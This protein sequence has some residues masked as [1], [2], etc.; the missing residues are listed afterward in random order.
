M[1]AVC[2]L[3]CWF[4]F[5]CAV[6]TFSN[7]TEAALTVAALAY[8]PW[9]GAAS[10][11]DDVK[12]VN[13]PLSLALAAA[14]C[15]VRP[16]AALYWLPMFV[17][18]SVKS[19]SRVR[20]ILN[21]ALPIGAAALAISTCVDRVF[22]GR[23]EIVPWN[24][25]GSTPWTAAAPSTAR[26]LG[27]GTSPRDTPAIATVFLPLA[28]IA[29]RDKK[30]WAPSPSSDG[31]FLGTLSPRTRSFGFC[32]RRWPDARRR[33]CAARVLLLSQTRRRGGANPSHADPRGA[34][35]VPPAPE[36]H[37]LGDVRADAAVGRRRAHSAGILADALPPAPV[38]HPRAQ[39]ERRHALSEVRSSRVRNPQGRAGRG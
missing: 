38:D 6:R 37:R 13:R 11:N 3:A 32:S 12:N 33:R 22:Y 9:T 26:T 7:C 23:W 29:C 8:W 30:R 1:G 4:N 2:S 10:E 15:V 5:F 28:A 34:V 24:F 18:E 14:A 25:S 17:E 36:R 21:E 19:V 35:P 16:A 39:T 20:F 31:P 27:T